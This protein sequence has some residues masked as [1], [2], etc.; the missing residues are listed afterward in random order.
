MQKALNGAR[1]SAFQVKSMT[2]KDFYAQAMLSSC[3]SLMRRKRLPRAGKPLRSASPWAPQLAMALRVEGGHAENVPGAITRINS[4]FNSSSSRA[5]SLKRPRK[6]TGRVMIRP[7]RGSRVV[8]LQRRSP[9]EIRASYHAGQKRSRLVGDL[10]GF[11]P[12]GRMSGEARLRR[13][14]A[15]PRDVAQKR[16]GL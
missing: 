3:H 10:W 1:H 7:N 15:I 11:T 5:R 8:R 16:K 6:A 14:F 2:D 13:R 4:V 12:P 9:K